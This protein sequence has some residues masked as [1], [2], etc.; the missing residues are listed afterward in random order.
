MPSAAVLAAVYAVT[1]AYADPLAARDSSTLP[2]IKEYHNPVISGFAP[3]PSCIRVDAQFFCVTS[4]FSAFPGI[5]VY[6]SRDLVQWQQIGACVC[7]L[8]LQYMCLMLIYVSY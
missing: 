2:R 8:H 1:S 3:D 7:V 5:P 4:S 6:T